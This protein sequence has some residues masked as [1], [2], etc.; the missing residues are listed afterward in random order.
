SEEHTS[1]LQSPCKL[2]CR[3]LLE[4]K[5]NSPNASPLTPRRSSVPSKRRG[6]TSTRSLRRICERILLHKSRRMQFSKLRQK[7]NA[8]S[9]IAFVMAWKWIFATCRRYNLL[10]IRKKS[11]RCPGKSNEHIES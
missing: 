8:P 2:V 10:S 3:L 11:L 4:K 1:E 6:T 5:K 7:Q 9:P